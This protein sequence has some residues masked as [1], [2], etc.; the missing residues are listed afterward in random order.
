MTLDLHAVQT[1][2]EDVAAIADAL[3]D[4]EKMLDSFHK[5]HGTA[6]YASVEAAWPTVADHGLYINSL[7]D[8]ARDMKATEAA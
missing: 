6:V 2:S 8:L 5:K 1:A 3:M 4:I 7:R